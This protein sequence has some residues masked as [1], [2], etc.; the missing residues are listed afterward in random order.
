MNS[1]FFQLWLHRRLIGSFGLSRF[2]SEESDFST[3]D[4]GLSSWAG[5]GPIPTA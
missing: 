4:T 3:S 5:S 2:L 1:K